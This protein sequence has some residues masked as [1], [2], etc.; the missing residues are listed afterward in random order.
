VHI[1]AGSDAGSHGVPHGRGLLWEMA[2]MERAGLGALTVLNAA[3]GA[4]AARL[5]FG[6]DFGRLRRGARPRFILTESSPLA[7]VTN[8][9]RARTVVCDGAVFATGDQAWPPGL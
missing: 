8:L 1:I 7:T 5:G 4:S 3:T 9:T 2:L 6:E